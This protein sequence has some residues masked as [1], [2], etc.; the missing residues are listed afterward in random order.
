MVY[1]QSFISAM[2]STAFIV[3]IARFLLSFFLVEPKNYTPSLCVGAGFLLGHYSFSGPTDDSDTVVAMAKFLGSAVCIIVLAAGFRY[4][5]TRTN[6][7]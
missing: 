4:R 7:T 1:F 3:I 2:V 5:A 6:V